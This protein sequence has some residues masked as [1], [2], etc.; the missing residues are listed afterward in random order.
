MKPFKIEPI[1]KPV[2]W[3][4]TK[5]AEEYGKIAPVSDYG[6][7]IIGESWEL[8]VTPFDENNVSDGNYAG[9]KLSQVPGCVQVPIIIKYIDA[10]DSLSVQVHPTKTE[11]WYIIDAAPGARIVY[12]L[13]KPFREDDFRKSL[14]D[15]T[16]DD[17]LSYT[18]VKPGDVFFIPT[19][20]VHALGPGILIAEIQEN[21]LDTY[22][23]YDFN[24]T[25]NGKPRELHVDAAM[26]VIRDFTADQLM[27]LRFSAGNPEKS[28]L[29]TVACCD[30]F[31]TFLYDG[32]SDPVQ[33]TVPAH[34]QISFMCIDGSGLINDVPAN[35][36][37]LLFLPETDDK[38]ALTGNMKVFI[39]Y[40]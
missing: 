5:L 30:K 23:V 20:L 11:M 1:C 37:D 18:E 32:T 39:S 19:G 16:L 22:R 29:K 26:K 9:K 38:I 35:K 40:R 6:K 2:L 8:A 7:N 3:G 12:G 17:Y 25:H 24:R 33:C 21:A 28:G 36:G 4:G 14:A 10:K 31:T 34:T 13:S 15:G 27:K